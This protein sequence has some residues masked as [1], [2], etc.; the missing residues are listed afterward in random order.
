M[1]CVEVYLFRWNVFVLYLSEAYADMKSKADGEIFLDTAEFLLLDP[2][3]VIT[4]EFYDFMG[5]IQ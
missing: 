5:E 2:Q 3:V 4:S 1:G